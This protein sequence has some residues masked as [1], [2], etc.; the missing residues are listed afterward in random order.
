MLNDFETE[1]DL[2]EPWSRQM[3]L[4]S[5]RTDPAKTNSINTKLVKLKENLQMNLS[6]LEQSLDHIDGKSPMA[7]SER[8]CSFSLESINYSGAEQ[9]GKVFK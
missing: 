3:L 4:K 1:D 9:L 7:A 8:A 2:F 6:K 5:D